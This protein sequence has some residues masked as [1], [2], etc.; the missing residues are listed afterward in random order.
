MDNNETFSGKE[1]EFSRPKPLKKLV[2]KKSPDSTGAA[3]VQKVYAD[4]PTAEPVGTVYHGKHEAS[5]VQQ[6]YKG[7]YEADPKEY[8][9]KHE[10]VPSDYRGKH[11]AIPTQSPTEYHSLHEIEKAPK[12]HL[13]REIEPAAEGGHVEEPA[14]EYAGSYKPKP[15]D[16]APYISKVVEEPEK[17]KISWKDI[18]IKVGAVACSL[19][20]IAGMI[21]NMP[22]LSDDD[23]D[24]NVSIVYYFKNKK[25]MADEGQINKENVRLDVNSDAVEDDFNDGLDLPQLIEGQYSILFLGFDEEEFNTDVM[26]VLEFDIGNHGLNILQIPRDCCL[27]DYTTSITKKFNSI[28]SMGDPN[29]NPPI[30]RVI[31]AVQENFGIPIDAYITTT[32][33]NIQDMVDLIG[34]IPIHIDNEIMYEADKI[35]PEGDVTLTGE[36]AEWFIRFRREWLLGDIGRM[37]NQRRFMA[38][39]MQKLFSI[40]KDEGRIKLYSYIKE[41]YN[42]RYLKTD[43]SLQDISMVADFASTLSMDNVTV[44]MV[45]GESAKFYASDGEVYDVYSVHKQATIDILNESFRP[46]QTKMMPWDTSIVELVTDYL[47]IDLDDT[48]TTLDEMEKATE[49][50]RDPNKS[51]T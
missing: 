9:P 17:K 38:A 35:I 31:N 28:Y 6:E 4:V 23:F 47:S 21:L 41:I 43:L 7:R 45:P 1:Q 46:Y 24:R 10:A 32:C 22:I 29:V 37:Q 27:P 33:F 8:Q 34:G 44:N 42:H 50:V 13:K 25:F 16:T 2:R 30:Q 26:W 14:Q 36:Q 3:P 51:P 11:E 5:P 49:P 39:A 12:S 15:G 18:A 48:G 19:V 20:L 40:V